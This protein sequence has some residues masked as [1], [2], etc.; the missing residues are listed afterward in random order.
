MN[1]ASPVMMSV[2][3]ALLEGAL[4]VAELAPDLFVL[5][6]AVIWPPSFVCDWLLIRI[7]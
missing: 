1:S 6:P 7:S 3:M 5:V 4:P 2:Q